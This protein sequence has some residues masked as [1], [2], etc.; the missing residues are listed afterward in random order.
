MR[1]LPAHAVFTRSEARAL[2][3]SDSAVT[4]AIRSGRII[5]LRRGQLAR[6]TSA[7]TAAADPAQVGRRELLLRAIAASR[8]CQGSVISHDS[9][10]TI[11]ALPLLGRPSARPALTVAPHTR[12]ALAGA[13]LHRATL[14]PE[15]VVVR[16]GV[17]VTS[18]ARTV[19]DL[20]RRLSTQAALVTL[21][22]ALHIHLTTREEL[23][24]GLLRCWNWPG[25]ARAARALRLGDARSE[26]AVESISRLELV[27]LGLP[28]PDLQPTIVAADSAVIGRVDF[29]WD[30]YGVVGEADGVGKYDRSAGSLLAEKRRQERLEDN[31]LVVLRW[32]W[33]DVMQRPAELRRR[34]EAAFE[35]GRRRDRSG[36]PRGW[37]VYEW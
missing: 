19:L 6:P 27:Q 18:V 12:G 8:D 35:R 22:A 16:D 4:R 5:R 34:L 17:E 2:G 25:V 13:R 23:D 31:G 37:S 32:G 7:E 33:E 24:A 21:D 15:D 11:H 36:S 10:A 28:R 3:W 30:E 26:S 9:A 29:Y 20:S 1:D 14:A